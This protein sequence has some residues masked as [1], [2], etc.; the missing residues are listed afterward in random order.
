M[1]IYLAPSLSGCAQAML[2]DLDKNSRKK[3][4]ALGGTLLL[5]F[6]NSGKMEVF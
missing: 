1:A 5:W 2:T 3:C 6:G 4:K